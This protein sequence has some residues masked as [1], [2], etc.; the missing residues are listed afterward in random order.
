MLRHFKPKTIVEIGSGF[1]SAEMLDIN[2]HF[3]G[4]QTS[5]HFIEPYPD[6]LYSLLSPDDRARCT[7]HE[8]PVQF[9]DPKVF[10]QLRENDILFIDS[11]HVAKKQSDVN[12]LLFEVLPLLQKGVIVHIHDIFWPFDYP[13]RWIEGGRAWN[14]AYF[15]RA[16]LQYNPTF[17]VL[18]FN[19]FL[20]SR[21]RDLLA[22]HLPS[23][24]K[25]SSFPDTFGNSS[26]WLKKAV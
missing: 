5:F 18:F 11:S 22:K 26:L 9:I 21:H 1:S 7:I 4:G 24:V 10:T 15:F 20:L 8:K 19:S 12:H 2:D 17:E 3:L 16:F 13:D 14:E 25:D 23:A 6:R